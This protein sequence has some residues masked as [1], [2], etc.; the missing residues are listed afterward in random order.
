MHLLERLFQRLDHMYPELVAFRR[1]MHM[2]PELSYQEEKTPQTIATYLA[3]CGI[4]VTANVGGRGVLGRLKG[5]KPGPTIAL[6]ADFDAL[7][8]Q[9]EK[10]VA[11]RSQVPGVMHACGHDI[12]TAALLGTARVLSENKDE[13][14]GNVLF[15]HQFAEE[16]LPGGAKAMIED[17]CLDGVDVIYGAHVWS[18]LPYG[19]VGVKEGYTM[20]GGDIFEIEIRGKGG[21]GAAP[22]LTVDPVVTGSQVVLNLQQIVSRKVDPLSPAVVTVGSFQ[23]GEAPNIVPHTAKLSGTIRALDEDVRQS[24]EAELKAIVNTTCDAAGAKAVIRYTHGRPPVWNHPQEAKRVAACAERLPD[25]L[26]VE[27]KPP[28]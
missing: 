4:D 10:T 28:R 25:V 15:V 3:D 22:H 16:A 21:H 5:G 13:L 18:E 6:R 2:F 9:D 24:I 14:R 23:T 19:T 7:P 12:H 20:A 27:Q 26:R 11:Y 17:G 1:E 8:I